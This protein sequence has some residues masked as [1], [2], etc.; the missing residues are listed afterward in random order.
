MKKL[1]IKYLN[2]QYLFENGY[3]IDK[4][5]ILYIKDDL[6]AVFGENILNEFNIFDD[7]LYILFPD[8][9]IKI[10]NSDGNWIKKTFDKKGNI[11]SYKDSDGNRLSYEDSEGFK[12]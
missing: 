11:L 2:S 5:N 12:N 6:K 8:K 3:I 4:F 1:I 7:W 9:V 10:K